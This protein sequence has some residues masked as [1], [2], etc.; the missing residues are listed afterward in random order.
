[1]KNKAMQQRLGD[2]VNE[3]LHSRK[4]LQLATLTEDGRPYASYAPFAIGDECLYVLISE[5]AVHATNLMHNPKASVLI[6]EDE[7]EAEKLF[8]RIRVN[9]HID[10]EQQAVDSEGWNIGL[11]ALQERH[12][13]IVTNL[14][15]LSD[16]KLFKLLPKGGR[17]VKNFGRAY[18]LAPDSLSSEVLA[19][20]TDGHKKR[21]EVA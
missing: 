19:H 11:A 20:M 21:E 3:F 4:S 9:Y 14:S 7:S 1:M 18:A 10:A 8:A 17:F 5:I 6:I 12:G 16:F 15:E 13:D 2:E